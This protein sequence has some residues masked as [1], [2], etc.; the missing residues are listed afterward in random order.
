MDIISSELRVVETDSVREHLP[1]TRERR[2]TGITQFASLDVETVTTNPLLPRDRKWAIRFNAN[3]T[4]TIVLGMR[5]YGN[6]YLSAYF[7]G[8]VAVRL[9]IP[10]RRIR[11]Y[12]S[13]TLPAVLQTPKPSRTLSRSINFGPVAGAAAGVIEAMCDRVI[14]KDRSALAPKQVR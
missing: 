14:E 3:G 1:L 12:Y 13:A 4:A 2:P 8:L 9:G 7:A 10:F 11:V 5:D 6:G